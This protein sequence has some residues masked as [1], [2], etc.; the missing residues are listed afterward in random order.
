[1]IQEPSHNI[2]ISKELNSSGMWRHITNESSKASLNKSPQ[3]NGNSTKESHTPE[4]DDEAITINVIKPSPDDQKS[5][6]EQQP[7]LNKRK[8]DEPGV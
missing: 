8:D 4:D 1:M 6:S 7:L 5:S 2:N 3:S